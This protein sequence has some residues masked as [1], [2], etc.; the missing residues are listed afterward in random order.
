MTALY[1]AAGATPTS[2]EQQVVTDDLTGLYNRRY[3]NMRLRQEAAHSIET[4]SHFSL[5][6]LDLDHFKEVND[7][8]GHSEGDQA[9]LWVSDILKQSV[10]SED[11]V[12]RFAGDEFFVI[13]P[14]AGKAESEAVAERIYKLILQNPF[15]GSC[16]QVRTVL[17]ISA[18]LA[19]FPED[20]SS[21]EELIRS[22]DKGLYLAKEQ[23]RGRFC[24]ASEA[25]RYQKNWL[26][27]A[28]LATPPFFG[29]EEQIHK[30]QMIFDSTV[31]NKE[32][33]IVWIHGASGIGKTRLLIEFLF[34]NN[35]IASDRLSTEKS[36]ILNSLCQ[37]HGIKIPYFSFIDLL[38]QW[39]EQ[40]PEHLRTCFSTLPKKEQGELLQLV[41]CLEVLVFTEECETLVPSRDASNLYYG[42]AHL[43][44]IAAGTGALV[45]S[46]EDIQW[47]DPASMD[48]LSHGIAQTMHCP[49]LF[50]LSAEWSLSEKNRLAQ[51]GSFLRPLERDPL[52]NDFLLP[53]LEAKDIRAI[54]QKIFHSE[55]HDELRAIEEILIQETEGNPLFIKEIL[56]KWVSEK[57][58]T[59]TPKGWRMDSL[60]S[61]TLPEKIKD[62]IDDRLRTLPED[63]K[64][65]LQL[66]AVIGR[67]F[68]FEILKEVSEKNEG[69][70]LDML[71]QAL[72][73][74]LVEEL[75]NA[76]VETYRFTS[77]NLQKVL[78]E[79]LS[80][81]RR[82]RAHQK[83]TESFEKL[84]SKEEGM[85]LLFHH[86]KLA[87]MPERMFEYG[88]KSALK[89]FKNHG[90]RE[91]D[92]FFDQAFL[93]F[94]ELSPTIK[95][96]FHFLYQDGAL[97]RA[98]TLIFLG[99]YKQAK[100]FL[101]TLPEWPQKQMLLGQTF[102]RLG[103]YDKSQEFYEQSLKH[104]CD[105]LF[106]SRIESELSELFYRQ[107]L[108]AQAEK[109]AGDAL[110]LARNLKN[111]ALEAEAYKA[112]GRAQLGQNQLLNAQKSNRESLRR[113]RT[114]QDWRG[115]LGCL[116]NIG[117]IA[118]QRK[119][120]TNAG[121]WFLKAKTL[122]DAIGLHTM[123]LNLLNN[124]GNV[125]FEDGN[126]ARADACYSEC[127]QLSSDR[128][129]SSA[130]IASW[131]NLGGIHEKVDPKKSESFYN[132]ALKL[133]RQTGD[134]NREA[135]VYCS[136]GDIAASAN[137][138]KNAE[139][140]FLKSVEL[141]HAI[142]DE[143]QEILSRIKLMEWFE[144]Q[145]QK[146]KTREWFLSTQTFFEERQAP[147]QGKKQRLYLELQKIRE[148]LAEKKLLQ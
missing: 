4:Q 139:T 15:R 3:L 39:V 22:A 81:A 36:F 106:Q 67:E 113:Y 71:D 44:K 100:E 5:L 40:N 115:I 35:R 72:S 18:G 136:L 11:V 45:F 135:F 104:A 92:H 129:D 74:G 128:G 13:L 85:E 148:R 7:T 2:L 97:H 89:A 55:S 17:G 48:L 59:L 140:L 51:I 33:N 118:Y 28:L 23:G 54:V 58:L 19:L 132:K 123:K 146:E 27:S 130:M 125:Y 82:K 77:L 108:F 31:K 66:A 20:A 73:L 9:L 25:N 143:E 99:K 95:K 53:P 126:I 24:L 60:Q 94:S 110:S 78:Y 114:I 145:N 64:H 1:K 90:L 29:R 76:R 134:K 107:G 141:S 38:T 32:R 147:F 62:V 56:W 46:F 96:L 63:T 102:L 30:L 26:D 14:H 50:L 79:K 142:E 101:D 34:N 88:I 80:L 61:L 68:T 122:C 37:P 93:V 112:I 124:L 70:L 91:A 105:P 131:L 138:E 109:H 8:Y 121:R 49:I 116:N 41:P 47:M 10:R 52:F 98:E 87:K 103:V 75:S 119:K 127:L 16:E 111:I 84:N 69:Y 21:P 42:L 12:I 57:I 144:K 43:F 65:V 137:D 120:L 117:L 86:A 83:I 133:S 6:M